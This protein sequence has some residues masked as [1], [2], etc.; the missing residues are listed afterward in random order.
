MVAVLFCLALWPLQRNFV[1]LSNDNCVGTA[2]QTKFNGF[3]RT[4]IHHPPVCSTLLDACPGASTILIFSRK[5]ATTEEHQAESS[6]RVG[7][8]GIRMMSYI[9]YG[10]QQSRPQLLGGHS[11]S[12]W[13]LC[14]AWNKYKIRV[15]SCAANTILGRI[16]PRCIQYSG[17][18]GIREG[19]MGTPLWTQADFSQI[20]T[21]GDL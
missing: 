15:V 8:L 19:K 21:M 20:T 17:F 2:A 12:P 16:R 18:G 9:F 13:L 5:R 3:V 4:T 1:S 6:G 11:E 7:P 10:I 14:A